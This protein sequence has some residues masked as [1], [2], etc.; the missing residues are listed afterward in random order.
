MSLDIHQKIIHANTNDWCR[1][2]T[3]EF[4][5]H[6]L[7]TSVALHKFAHSPRFL[8]PANTYGFMLLFLLILLD[9]IFLKEKVIIFFNKASDP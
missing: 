2:I 5:N 4:A 9:A 7:K 3:M 8:S 1:N 6:C